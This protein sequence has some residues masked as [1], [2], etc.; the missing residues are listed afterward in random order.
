MVHD[1]PGAGCVVVIGPA[2]H[3]F[4]GHWGEGS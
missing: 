3:V 2:A 1:E 4:A